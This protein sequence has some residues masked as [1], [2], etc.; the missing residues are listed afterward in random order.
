ML[1]SKMINKQEFE[2]ISNLLTSYNDI[3]SIRLGITMLKTLNQDALNIIHYTFI[4]NSE[5]YSTLDEIEKQLNFNDSPFYVN[6]FLKC[7]LYKLSDALNWAALLVDSPNFDYIFT[8][9]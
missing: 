8:G 9:L 2:S 7:Y 3:E 6:Y 5:F 4:P 1:K